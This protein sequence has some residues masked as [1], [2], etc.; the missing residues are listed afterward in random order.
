MP[1]IRKNQHRIPQ[2]YLRQ[3]CFRDAVS[4]A[5]KLSVMKRFDPQ[6]HYKSVKSFTTESNLF[7]SS[8]HEAGHERHFDKLCITVEHNY[9]KVLKALNNNIYDEQTRIY[10]SEFISNIFVRQQKTYNFFREIIQH[11]DVRKKFFNEIT[12]F[13]EDA[14]PELTK[15]VLEEMAIDPDHT[16]DSKTS[17]FILP[18]WKHF[19]IA[20]S[21]FNHV[22]LKAG[23]Q[24]PWL[25]T[26]NPVILTESLDDGWIISQRTEIYFP[27]S[28]NYLLYMYLDGGSKDP[29]LSKL[30]SDSI[31]P[32]KSKLVDKIMRKVV[33][34]SNYDYMIMSMNMGYFDAEKNK[35]VERYTPVEFSKHRALK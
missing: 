4:K 27:I 13:D 19:K 33:L 1:L 5:E 7:D 8:L 21:R 23:D 30:K 10:L 20:F 29:K 28:K 14:S 12:I 32:V 6:T 16:I 18:A 24:T 31:H 34:K 9:T 3:W 17:T 35:H 11:S 15:A 25:T 26:D 2:V 22:I